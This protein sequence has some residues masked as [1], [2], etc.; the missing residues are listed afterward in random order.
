[1]SQEL[2]AVNNPISQEIVVAKKVNALSR[3]FTVKPATLE[4]VSKSTR[5]ETATPGTFRVTQ[6]NESFKEMRVVMIFEPVEQR[7][8]YRKG[9]YTKD[10]KEC[11]SLAQ[12]FSTSPSQESARALLCKLPDGRA[13]VGWVAQSQRQRSNRRSVNSTFA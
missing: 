8:M 10:A 13:Y 11:F 2:T 4:L 6:T 1:M 3:L 7:E 12:H 5:Q 9:E